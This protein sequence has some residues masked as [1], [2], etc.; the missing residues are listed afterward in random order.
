MRPVD[1]SASINR[2]DILDNKQ[3]DRG[4]MYVPDPMGKAA[5]CLC[6]D[7]FS[8][9]ENVLGFREARAAMRLQ[10]I[11]STLTK[12]P[13]FPIVPNAPRR[14]SDSDFGREA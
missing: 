5:H 2:R 13:L 8:L 14:R 7:G 11:E 12:P 1:G 10:R 9:D 6:L 3:I 4:K